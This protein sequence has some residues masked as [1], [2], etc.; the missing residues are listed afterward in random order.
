MGGDGGA[1]VLTCP[2]PLPSSILSQGHNVVILALAGGW[3]ME[4][5]EG[6]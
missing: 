3:R 5:E 6:I 1:S 2:V 4:E